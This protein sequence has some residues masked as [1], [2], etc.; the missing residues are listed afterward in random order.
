MGALVRG[1]SKVADLPGP[2]TGF[3]AA[4]APP[5]RVTVNNRLALRAGLD[6]SSGCSGAPFNH[7]AIPGP[8]LIAEGSETVTINGRPMARTSMK[9]VCGAKIKNGSNDVTVGGPTIRVVA[10]NDNE[11]M[12][13]NALEILG[14]VSLGAGLLGALAAGAGA[15][16]LFLGV[17]GGLN[18]ALGELHT[19]GESLGPGYGDIFAG[20]AGLGLLGLGAR[21]ARTPAGRNA[22]DVLNRTKIEVRPGTLGMNGGNVR[23]KLTPKPGASEGVSPQGGSTYKARLDQTPVKNGQWSGKRGESKW[24]PNDPE[25]TPYLKDSGVDGINYSNAQP[26]FAPVAKGQVE[27]P[28]MTTNRSKN[29]RAADEALAKEWGVSPKEVAKWRDQNSYTWHEQPDLVTMQLMP[30]KVNGK[31]GH[32][33]GVGEIKAGKVKP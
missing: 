5:S 20:I 33:G 12:F 26:D 6:F 11:E 23:V 2:T 32:L 30:S 18:L 14:W 10:V 16:I 9:L 4:A 7:F 19:W 31:L 24:K 1:I 22:I 28:N 17:T 3:L 25:V 8:L 15:T 13:E 21:G 27:I 29:F